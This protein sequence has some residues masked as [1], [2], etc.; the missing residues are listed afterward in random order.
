MPTSEVE[1]PRRPFVDLGS[2]DN[3]WPEA[4]CGPA[5]KG[6]K[7]SALGV[8]KKKVPL[9]HLALR[10]GW[11]TYFYIYTLWPNYDKI[12]LR[13]LDLF[14]RDEGIHVR[15]PTT[16]VKELKEDTRQRRIF[17]IRPHTWQRNYIELIY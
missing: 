10:Q 13:C 4:V 17:N 5:K 8:P 7:F 2:Q 1:R 12:V 6:R 14:I 15:I 9:Y 3:A 11:Q 16:K